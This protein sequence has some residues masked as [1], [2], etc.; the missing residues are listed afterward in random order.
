MVPPQIKQPFGVY[1]YPGLIWNHSDFPSSYVSK[2]QRVPSPPR[3]HGYGSAPSSLGGECHRSRARRGVGVG[4]H[5]RHVICHGD[6]YHQI[7]PWPPLALREGWCFADAV[8][9]RWANWR[10]NDRH[11]HLDFNHDVKIGSMVKSTFQGLNFSFF[12]EHGHHYPQS[13]NLMFHGEIPFFLWPWFVFEYASLILN[14]RI[15]IFIGGFP[16]GIPP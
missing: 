10:A 12:M 11:F 7:V 13:I 5:C 4:A 3:P 8:G 16:L 1:Y 15:S 2:K 14:D 6:S 9:K